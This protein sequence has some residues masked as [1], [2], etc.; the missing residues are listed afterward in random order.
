MKVVGGRLIALTAV[1]AALSF[2][3][4]LAVPDKMP[5]MAVPKIVLHSPL[6]TGN[7]FGYAV[8]ATTGNIV[9]LY[10]HPY[11][12][13]R[14]NPDKSKD[15][16]NTYNFLK[17]L[18]WR[19][20]GVG[21]AKG[22]Q[23]GYLSES[24]VLSV[25]HDGKEFCYFMPFA[26][27]RN[28]LIAV[29]RSVKKDD[30]SLALDAVWQKAPVSEK[31]V[32]IDGLKVRHLTFA[33]VKESLAIVPLS[34]EGAP[35]D[36]GVVAEGPGTHLFGTAFAF[37][38]LESPEQLKQAVADLRSWQGKLTPDA[39]IEKE[40]KDLETWRVKPRYSFKSDKERQL[41]RQNE[42]IMRM[43]QIMEPNT[44]KRFNHGL[45]LA[46]LPD[47]VWFTPWVRDMT[48]ALVGLT[49]MGHHKEARLGIMSWFNARP[50]GLWKHETRDLDYQ[51]SVVRYYGDGSEEADYSGLKTPNVEFDDWGLALWAVSEYWKETHDKSLFSEKTYRGTVYESMRD[52][53]VKP[54]LGN[55]DKYQDGLIVAEDSSCWEEHQENK[56]HYA[57]ST[58]CA[59]A[60]LR[61]FE[62]IAKEMNDTA[63][64]K[65]VSEKI[66]LLD[67]GFRAAFIEGGAVRGILEVKAQAKTK[68]D[69]AVLEAFNLGVLNDPSIANR[70]IQNMAQLKTPS[71]GYRRNLGP[72]NYEAH[73]FLFIDFALARLY[74]KTGK[75]D[76]AAKILDTIVDKSVQ[77]RGLI[78]EMYVSAKGKDAP[79]EIGDPA[80]AIPMVGYGA[81]AFVITLA[82]R[83]QYSKGK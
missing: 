7:G 44:N 50:V 73:E 61:G 55:L 42:T 11:R 45:I 21:S 16:D 8:L 80:G 5:G 3:A 17:R 81:G 59:I 27:K 28:A 67:K 53:I 14:A 23:F 43:A 48:Y 37:V 6:V 64:A 79:G 40:L 38:V 72:S 13:E 56:H 41:W 77:D 63:T 35:Q 66:R 10:A 22:A 65:M 26:L 57:F 58:I 36:I 29:K 20:P 32:T 60:G 39:L 49:K 54:L 12:F 69:G 75:P 46:S 68:V 18:S 76:Q 19:G 74:W 1:A 82:D 9:K 15:G 71:G 2:G 52:F 62:S 25:K 31:S 34:A 83:E 51:I 33:G 47:G 30:A 70:T 24:Q 4:A 78:P